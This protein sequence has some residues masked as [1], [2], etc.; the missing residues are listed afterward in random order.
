MKYPWQMT[1][2]EAE[3]ASG[4]RVGQAV[5]GKHYHGRPKETPSLVRGVVRGFT[6]QPTDGTDGTT[7]WVDVQPDDGEYPFSTKVTDV[8]PV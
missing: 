6:Y 7:L 5:V 8:S 1:V 2:A 3:A 4:F